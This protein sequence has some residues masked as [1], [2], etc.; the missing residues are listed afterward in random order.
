MAAVHPSVLLHL[1]MTMTSTVWVINSHRKVEFK[2]QT[3]AWNISAVTSVTSP[4]SDVLF[5]FLFFFFF[6]ESRRDEVILLTTLLL[7]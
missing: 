2:T 5:F 1:K 4:S 3:L 6:F 7:M